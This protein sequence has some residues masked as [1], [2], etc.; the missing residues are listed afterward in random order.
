MKVNPEIF[1]GYDIRGITEKDLSSEIMEGIAKAYANW[2]SRRRIRDCVVGMDCRSTGPEYKKAIIK[3]LTESGVNVVDIGRCTSPMMYFA[4]YHYKT[5]GGIMITASH[6]PSEWNGMKLGTGYSE[7]M[8]TEEIQEIRAMVE[9]DEF[10]TDAEKGTVTQGDDLLEAYTEDLLKRVRIK[11]KFKIVVDA[12]A[13][14][15]GE[16]VPDILRAAG[17]EVIEE[18]CEID[19]SFPVGTPDPTEKEVQERLAKKVLENKADIGFSYD[20]DGDRLGVV[21]EKGNLMWNDIIVALLAADV[22]DFLPGAKIVY[23]VLCS[24][25]VDDVIKEKKGQPIMWVTGHSFIKE[26]AAME[27]AQFAGELSGHFFFIDNF[28]GH[29]DG[30]FTS[31]RLLEYLANQNKPLSEIVAALPQYISSPEIKLECPDNKKKEVLK[32]ITDNFKKEYAD[33]EIIDIDGVRVDWADRMLVI[34]YSQNGPYLT[35]KYE[36]KEQAGYDELKKI[37]RTELEKYQEINWEEG[38]NTEAL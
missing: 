9:N 32:Q 35:V 27:K 6:N 3:G 4:Q 23:N 30:A 33:Q 14:T 10:I 22:I 38:V 25:V 20:A 7:T 37:I 21:D 5:N 29:D 19:P 12:C 26:K 1:R 18:N 36:A 16:T 15:P 24:K 2:L 28:Y 31:L 8:V 13:A 11:K 34:R 17:A